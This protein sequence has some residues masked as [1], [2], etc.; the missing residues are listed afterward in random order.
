MIKNFSIDLQ[1]SMTLGLRTYID[2]SLNHFG[3]P[4]S[5]GF[6]KS[7]YHLIFIAFSGILVLMKDLQCQF[8]NATVQT[9]LI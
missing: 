1:H 4:D 7:K 5:T 6:K 9:D 3:S 8:G 2:T